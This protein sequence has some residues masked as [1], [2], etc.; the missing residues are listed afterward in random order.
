MLVADTA[1]TCFKCHQKTEKAAQGAGSVHA[2]FTVGDC[3]KCHGAHHTKL[4]QLQL[5]RAPDLCLT[6]HKDLKTE[7]A[8]ERPHQPVEDCSTCHLPHASKHA[9]LA[10]KPVREQC[11]ECH[12]PKAP[13]FSEKHLGIAAA[14]MQC[15]GCHDPHASK[16]AS[17]LK[18]AIHAPFEAREC[19]ACHVVEKKK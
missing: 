18:P 3:T 11:G 7:L 4:K 9:R 8:A 17:F 19:E 12:D 16:D 14:D 10:T 13:A 6:C 1:K 2:A 5:A 15:L